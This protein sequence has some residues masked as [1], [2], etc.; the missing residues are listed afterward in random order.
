M[1]STCTTPSRQAETRK[2]FEFK[3]KKDAALYT[4]GLSKSSK[5]P[6][7]S[8]GISALHCNV[9]SK[10]RAVPGSTCYKCYAR[11]GM[12]V[13]PNTKKAHANRFAS[14][15]DL[16]TW[17]KAMIKLIDGMPYFRWHDSGDLQSFDHLLAIVEVCKATPETKHWIPTRETAH[18]SNYMREYGEFP[19]NMIVRV[20]AT[21]IDKAP[22][23]TWDHTSSVHD[24]AEPVGHACQAYRTGKDGK[25]LSKAKFKALPKGHDMDLGHCGNCRKCWD[26]KTVNISYGLH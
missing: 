24:K 20:S 26:K 23:P 5:M 17:S 22:S 14:L 2:R 12:Y 6:C 9:G 1:T 19:K 16:E 8:Y 4:G 10:M 3:T 15:A 18:I 11:K 7:A 13:M 25:M 21:M